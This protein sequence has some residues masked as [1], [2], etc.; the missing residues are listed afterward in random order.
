[1]KDFFV[2]KTDNSFTLSPQIAGE[3][4]LSVS[5]SPDDA[6]E[7]IGVYSGDTT[8]ECGIERPFFHALWQDGRRSTG[9]LHTVAA[10]GMVNLRDI[11]GY[12]GDGGF[13]RYNAFYRGERLYNLTEKGAEQFA[14]LGV[15]YIADYRSVGE[16]ASRPDPERFSSVYHGLPAIVIEGGMGFSSERVPL[17]TDDDYAAMLAEFVG[18]YDTLPFNSTAYRHLFRQLVEGTVPVYFH[19]TAGK[20]RTGFAAALILTAL[21]VPYETVEYDYLISNTLRAGQIAAIMK[22]CEGLTDVAKT[23]LSQML[24][25]RPEY[26]RRSF[27]LIRE[28]YGSFERYMEE[29]L[30][31]TK[32]ERRLLVE[33]YLVRHYR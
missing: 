10:E 7:Y 20:D 28:R 33:K 9:A 29:D 31:V 1:M 26:L 12:N 2:T 24:N 30:L 4:E 6:G 15:R 25:V 17:Y 32:S 16:A 3:Y 19:C 14:A 5:R 11:G 21:G 27:S 18:Y 13:V 8:V 23:S 22:L